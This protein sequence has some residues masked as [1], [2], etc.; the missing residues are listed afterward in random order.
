LAVPQKQRVFTLVA[1]QSRTDVVTTVSG[2]LPEW[3]A[4]MLRL[5]V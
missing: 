2:N 5:Y 1:K 4:G 3:V